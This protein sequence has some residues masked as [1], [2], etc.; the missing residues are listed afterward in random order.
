LD[1]ATYEQVLSS[2]RLLG[3][4]SP[5]PL[6]PSRRSI[7]PILPRPDAR[8]PRELSSDVKRSSAKR[9]QATK[10]PVQVAAVI[11]LHLV[12]RKRPTTPMAERQGAVHAT[13][14]LY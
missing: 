9:E 1:W 11:N 10:K 7:T 5:T 13:V 4:T 14:N 12:A 8:Q 3:A 6:G 2:P